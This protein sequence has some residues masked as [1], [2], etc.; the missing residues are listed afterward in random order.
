MQPK[1]VVIGNGDVG[2]DS[3]LP[4]S[5]KLIDQKSINPVKSIY[6][7][8][9]PINR[10]RRKR[11][12][13]K[14]VPDSGNPHYYPDSGKRSTAEAGGLGMVTALEFKNLESISNVSVFAKMF[15]VLHKIR[16]MDIIESVDCEVV[17]LQ[18]FRKWGAFITLDDGLTPRNCL[19]ARIVSESKCSVLIDMQRE[20]NSISTLLLVGNRAIQFDN[21]VNGIIKGSIHKSGSWPE[22]L[23]NDM[24]NTFHIEIF[25]FKHTNADSETM[26][27]RIWGKIYIM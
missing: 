4:S 22:D 2:V 19:I 7:N 8:F 16:S 10:K 26:A 11:K 23:L 13:S 14:I 18:N 6:T 9:V 20:S 1:R 24:A 27:R 5:T 3:D 25:H 21:I 12:V 15:E 17:N